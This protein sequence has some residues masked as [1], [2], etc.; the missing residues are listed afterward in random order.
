MNRDDQ[1]FWDRIAD[2]PWLEAEQECVLRREN[3]ALQ[4]AM[5]TQERAR[6]QDE[7]GVRRGGEID[8]IG[9]EI[10]TLGSQNCVLN[11]RIKYMRKVG[12]IVSWRKAVTE[13]LGREAYEQIAEH[14]ARTE[15]EWRKLNPPK[16]S[17]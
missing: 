4:I 14:L 8:R 11:E 12:D 7:R 2:M 10:S 17:A 3:N 6:L 16:V 9:V 15:W 1:Q 5:L 13:V